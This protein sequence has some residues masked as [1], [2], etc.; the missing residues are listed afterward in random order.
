MK[1]FLKK[2]YAGWMAFA[3]VL[4]II[5]STILLSVLYFVIFPWIAVPRKFFHKE[6]K[7]PKWWPFSS[8][9]ATEKNYSHQ[10]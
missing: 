5:N 8:P 3:K 6:I 1:N 4:G 10:F 7:L 9:S 2:V